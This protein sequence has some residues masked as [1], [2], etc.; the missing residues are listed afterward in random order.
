MAK[1]TGT[2]WDRI[3]EALLGKKKGKPFPGNV[4]VGKHTIDK[5]NEKLK[6]QLK[7]SGK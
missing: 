4:T 5:Q 3:M 2:I 1:K 7:E 6:K